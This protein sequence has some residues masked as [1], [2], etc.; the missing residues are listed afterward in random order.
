MQ[1]KLQAYAKGENVS[2]EMGDPENIRWNLSLSNPIYHKP[3]H[4]LNTGVP[5]AVLFYDDLEKVEMRE[6]GK[7][8]RHHEAFGPGGANVNAAMV[9]QNGE[10]HVRTFERGVEDE[11]LA[12]GTGMTAVAL[13]A[14]K[15]L[16]LKGPIQ[17][18]PRSKEKLEVDFNI[19]DETFKNV[20]LTGPATFVFQGEFKNSAFII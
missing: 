11:T 15:L 13:A 6:L 5:H 4:F 1:R 3:L 17:L 16:K 10:I 8:F 7:A 18:F 20:T 2:V 14:A 9:M 19:V 12:C